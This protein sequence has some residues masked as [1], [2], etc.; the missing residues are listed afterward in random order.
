MFELIYD[1]VDRETFIKYFRLIVV[2]SVY[3]LAR[4]IYS[5]Y[6]KTSMIKRQIKIDEREKLEKPE[7]ERKK[8]EDKEKKLKE[9]AKTF[10]WGKK[11]RRNIKL[12]EQVLID[13]A[14]ELRFRAQN[15]YDAAEDN[16][17]ED[18]LED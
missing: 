9:E 5:N 13:T 11:T 18:L 17:I 2:V 8:V 6:A 12:Q 10:G 3:I 7:K 1:W 15:A 14:D 4:R 16:D